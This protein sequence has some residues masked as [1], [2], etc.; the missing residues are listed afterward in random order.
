MI[1]GLDM[2]TTH[3]IQALDVRD[4]SDF[5]HATERKLHHVTHAVSCRSLCIA[6]H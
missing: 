3:A 2:V 4:A 1:V 5:W 6:T